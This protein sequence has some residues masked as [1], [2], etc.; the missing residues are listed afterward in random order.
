MNNAIC[1]RCWKPFRV[2][3]KGV[4]RVYCSESCKRKAYRQ[5]RKDTGC[6]LCNLRA[7]LQ[8]MMDQ[9]EAIPE[10]PFWPLINDALSE[11]YNRLDDAHGYAS[12]DHDRGKV[13]P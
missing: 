10:E 4:P 9:I 8:Q 12:H 6:I 7:L 3:G 13:Q 1:P 5:G 11:A 2:N